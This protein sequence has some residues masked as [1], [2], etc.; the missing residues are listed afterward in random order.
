MYS[1]A[2]LS[3]YETFARALLEAVHQHDFGVKHHFGHILRHVKSVDEISSDDLKNRSV[4]SC[5]NSG[6][7]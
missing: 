1:E 2:K 3:Q 5:L 7:W 6:S 4:V